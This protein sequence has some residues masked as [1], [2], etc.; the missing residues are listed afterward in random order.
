MFRCRFSDGQAVGAPALR[1][2][3][4]CPPAPILALTKDGSG[5]KLVEQNRVLF[6]GVDV[7]G[8]SAVVPEARSHDAAWLFSTVTFAKSA[9]S[10]R[11][12]RQL[13]RYRRC[14]DFRARL[15]PSWNRFTEAPSE[16]LR[17]RRQ[18]QLRPPP[19]GRRPPPC[20]PRRP[21]RAALGGA[22]SGFLTSTQARLPP[23]MNTDC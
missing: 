19:C 23:D 5:T 18:L 22:S 3:P 13:R 7:A 11:G 21:R 17:L 9:I 6:D 4:R 10:S 12:L 14:R 20:G 8:F 15:S 1:R 16:P 2:A